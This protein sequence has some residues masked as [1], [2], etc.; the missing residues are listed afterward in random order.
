MTSLISVRNRIRSLKG[1]VFDLDGTLTL[2][3]FKFKY[4]P[5]KGRSCKTIWHTTGYNM[6]IALPK[7]D[8]GKSGML[9]RGIR[10]SGGSSEEDVIV[11]GFP[12]R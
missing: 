11:C 5:I 2:V 12:D 4:K 10:C 1:V 9:S 7:R 3:K 8:T 6:G